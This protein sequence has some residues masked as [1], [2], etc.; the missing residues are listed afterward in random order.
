MA[1]AKEFSTSMKTRT[2]YC[3]YSCPYKKGALSPALRGACR[4][5]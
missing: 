1:F 2:L 3:R 4:N 5:V